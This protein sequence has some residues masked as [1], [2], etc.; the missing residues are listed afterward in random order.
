[1]QKNIILAWE[2]SRLQLPQKRRSLGEN[3]WV[4]R[5]PPGS[6]GSSIF[7]HL[8]CYYICTH[9]QRLEEENTNTEEVSSLEAELLNVSHLPNVVMSSSSFHL[10]L[11]P[12]KKLEL[13]LEAAYDLIGIK[14]SHFSTQ[15]LFVVKEESFYLISVV[16]I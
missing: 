1:M 15:Q 11:L 14:S 6:Q 7:L 9:S 16:I 13:N 3:V 2:C 4:P 12:K 5:M 8:F 10:V